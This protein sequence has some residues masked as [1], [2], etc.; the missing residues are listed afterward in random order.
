VNSFRNALFAPTGGKSDDDESTETTNT[1]TSSLPAISP[2]GST[3]QAVATPTSRAAASTTSVTPQ[4]AKASVSSPSKPVVAPMSPGG[5]TAVA[6]TP[7]RQA[8]PPP[9]DDDDDDD[10]VFNPYQFM[11]QLPPHQYVKIPNKIVL[12]P[13]QEPKHPITLVLD[14]DETLVHCSV[15]PIPNPDVIFP[16]LFNGVN[17]QVHVRKR[18][19]LDYFLENIAP[20]YEVVL[21]TA[22]QKVYAD[23][24]CEYIDPKQNMIRHRLFRDS[25]LCVQGN[26]VK[27]IDVLGRDMKSVSQLLFGI[28]SLP[29]MTY[30]PIV[31][32]YSVRCRLCWWTTLLML[33]PTTTIT[34][35]PLSPGMTKTMTRSC[36]SCWAFLRTSWMAART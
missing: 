2:N 25:C 24:L 21:F 9:P 23:K 18:P 4:M 35:S 19:Y 10:D 36:S 13:M 34:A 1:K 8:A 28:V 11:Y 6:V 30:M 31:M 27:D 3:S 16:V 15:E 5:R 22:S 12:P 20:H 32:W 17:Y 14:L 7:T 33:T 29:F 26:Y